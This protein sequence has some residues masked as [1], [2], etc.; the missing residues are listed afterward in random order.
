MRRNPIADRVAI[1]GVGVA[2]YA[3]NAPGAT[4]GSLAIRASIAAIRDAGLTAADID[5]VCGSTV[6]AQYLQ[7]ALGFGP[8][9]WFANPSVPIGNQLVAA[10]N[11]IHA[12]ACDTVLVCHAV[13]R[14]PTLSRSAGADP[15]RHRAALGLRLDDPR[16]FLGSGHVEGEPWGLFG[17][18]GYAAWAGRYVH[19][20][21]LP[22]EQLG[23]IAVNGRTNAAGNDNAV[24]RDPLTIDDY[25]TGR[26]VREPLCLYDMDVAVDGADAFVLTTVE[27]ARDLDVEP[28]LVHAAS[29]GQAPEWSEAGTVDL[30]HTG[31]AVV[32]DAL[33]AK[34][35]LGLADVDV[36]LPYDGFS[37][38]ALKWFESVGYCGPGE[39]G[40]FL[41]SHWDDGRQRIDIDGRVLVNPHGGSLSEGATQGSGHVREA[42]RQLRGEAGPRQRDRPRVALVTTGGFFFNAQGLVLRTDG[43]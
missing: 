11:A 43:A 33:W 26:M 1:V 36:F 34:A 40:A 29:L 16:A 3:R 5:G 42:V 39:A 7:P 28:V 22:R 24:Y 17:A 35:D 27:R 15:L 20:H 14:R 41:A 4:Y 6:N 38:I 30:E 32:M 10:M 13:L 31:Q 12:G 18:A 25:L 21:H 8:L 9:T 37:I 19:D 23:L 2:P